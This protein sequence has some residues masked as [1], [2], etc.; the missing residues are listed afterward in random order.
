ML[1]RSAGVAADGTPISDKVT[2]KYDGHDYPV[3]G[4]ADYDTVSVKRVN[5]TTAKA[6]Q[7]K[8]GKIVGSAVRSVSAHG[9]VLTLNVKG[10]DAKGIAFH[11]I[12]VFDKQ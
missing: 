2:Y 7:K 5:G 12:Y 6:T 10:K 4:S 3:S 9:K 1:F 8:N 11:N